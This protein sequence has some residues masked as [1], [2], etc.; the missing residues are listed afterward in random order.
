M[1]ANFRHGWQ[2]FRSRFEALV[3]TTG[4]TLM[5]TM[6]PADTHASLCPLRLSGLGFCPGCGLGLSIA[7]L[8]RGEFVQSFHAHPLGM[9]AVA[10][11]LWRIYTILRKPVFY[12]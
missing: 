2:Y 9:A 8:F 12:Y 5:A 6:R 7:W 1:R 3:W 10:I 11:L 4:L